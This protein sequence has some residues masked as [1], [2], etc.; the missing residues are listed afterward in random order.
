MQDFL[1]DVSL[2]CAVGAGI[3]FLA[4][5]GRE[6]AFPLATVILAGVTLVVSVAGNLDQAILDALARNREQLLS[7]ELWRIFTPL[8]VQDG[9]WAGTI[10]NLVSLLFIGAV[11]E[12]AFGR[13]TLLLT[14][15]TAG[16]ASEI[17]A[18]TFLQHQGFAGNSVAVLGLAGLC[19]VTFAARERTFTR[20]LAIVGLLAGATLL[21]TGNL[22]GIGFATGA[23][24]GIVLLLQ[25]PAGSTDLT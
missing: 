17:A 10:F 13:K 5:T 9:G 16:L 19:L 23:I 11:T 22:H 14:Y 8:F 20:A 12:I 24:V 21:V 7:G 25:A 15:F 1:I 6:F 3:R 18:Y 2:A 4:S